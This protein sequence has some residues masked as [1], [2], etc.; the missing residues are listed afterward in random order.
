MLALYGRGA[1]C[2]RIAH[3]LHSAYYTV[4]RALAS[5]G[6]VLRSATE[7]RRLQAEQNRRVFS[8]DER[9]TLRELYRVYPLGE[10]ARRMHSDNAR[11]ARELRAMNVP[12]RPSGAQKGNRNNRNARGKWGYIRG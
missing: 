7:S 11:V 5:M 1:S 6:V 3:E 4:R 12:I 8:D 2:E 10:V 9:A